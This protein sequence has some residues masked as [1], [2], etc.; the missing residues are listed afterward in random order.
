VTNPDNL[1]LLR[2]KVAAR[3]QEI[4]GEARGVLGVSVLDLTGGESFGVNE[5]L[6]FP[7]A[8][9][10]K[11]AVLM[12]VYKQAGEGRFQLSDFRSIRHQDKSGG[13][14]ILHELGDDTVRLSL[15]DLCVLMILVSDNTATNMLVDLVG[16][17]NMNRTLESLGCRVTR[18]RRRM[19]DMAAAARGDEN[20][21]TPAEAVRIMALLHRGEFVSRAVC[22][23]ILA[24]LK[25]R[26]GGGIAAGLPVDVPI[27]SKPGAIGGVATEWAIVL[28]QDRPY[29]VAV[30]ENYAVE[31]EPG[32]AIKQISQTLYEY[33]LRLARSS[34]HGLFLPPAAQK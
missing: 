8:S 13:S 30:M 18:V 33:F 23:E 11:I 34:P 28:L 7:Q 5:Q 19:M 20:V 17:E 15:R 32:A 2:E 9:A 12:E 27:A 29:A 6:V 22:D 24:I 31:P 16:M 26:K 1:K 25:K 3:L 10:I 14:G 21:S 4:A